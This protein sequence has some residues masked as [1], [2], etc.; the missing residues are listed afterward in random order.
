MEIAGLPAA[1]EPGQ[2]Y[3]VTVTVHRAG[4]ERAGFQLAVRFASGTPGAALQAGSLAV[5]EAARTGIDRDSTAVRTVWYA[6]HTRAGTAATAGQHRWTVRWIAPLE[7][8]D[9]VIHAASV[10]AN[11]DNSNFGDQ[12]V[13]RALRVPAAPPR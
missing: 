8:Q 5:V 1:F 11:D 10:A 2:S 4:L 7:R 9:V 3:D 12:V 6:R 13:T